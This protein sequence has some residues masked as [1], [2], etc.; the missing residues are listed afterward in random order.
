MKIIGGALA[1]GLLL[2]GCASDERVALQNDPYENLP[3]S[4]P[5]A[6]AVYPPSK[7]FNNQN[8]PHIVY[9]SGTSSPA[10]GP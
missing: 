8:E 4:R 5:G 7:D 2:S 1:I 6:V 10:N 9:P 3:L